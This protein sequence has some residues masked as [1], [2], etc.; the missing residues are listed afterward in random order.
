MTPTPDNT[1]GATPPERR[2]TDKEVRAA[3]LGDPNATE[4]ANAVVEKFRR[5][6]PGMMM[7]LPFDWA[8]MDD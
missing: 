5:E 8:D 2:A 3:L 6:N 4:E 7:D 1:S